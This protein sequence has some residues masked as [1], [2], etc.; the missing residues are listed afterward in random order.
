MLAFLAFPVSE[1]KSRFQYE[2][3]ERYACKIRACTLLRVMSCGFQWIR[4]SGREV[5]PFGR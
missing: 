4:R 3:I 1:F 2:Q 5:D